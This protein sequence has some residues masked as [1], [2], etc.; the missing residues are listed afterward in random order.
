M[1]CER[2]LMGMEIEKLKM[3]ALRRVSVIFESVKMDLLTNYLYS[4]FLTCEFNQ[5]IQKMTG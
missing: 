5:N 4:R 2:I 3:T 1:E